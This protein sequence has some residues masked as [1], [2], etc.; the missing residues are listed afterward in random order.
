MAVLGRGCQWGRCCVFTAVC[1]HLVGVAPCAVSVLGR[2]G[3]EEFGA[4]KQGGFGTQSPCP[5]EL[6]ALHWFSGIQ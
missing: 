6:C 2:V 4:D 5:V 1:S 3:K